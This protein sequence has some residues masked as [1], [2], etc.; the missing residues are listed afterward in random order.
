VQ[1]RTRRILVL[2]AL[3]TSAGTAAAGTT[4]IIGTGDDAPASD[5]F[6]AIFETALD[7]VNFDF[8]RNWAYTETRVD[9]EH[10]WVGRF[11]PRKPDGQRWNLL[12]VDDR[13]PSDDEN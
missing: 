3:T 10:V 1:T 8:A 9:N 13:A 11:D 5:D 4:A 6:K 12:S 2:I 7:G